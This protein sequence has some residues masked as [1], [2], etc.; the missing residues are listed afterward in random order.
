MSTGCQGTRP[1]EE[2]PQ[3]ND[4]NL[5]V[6]EWRGLDAVLFDLRT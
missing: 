4:E 2:I 5:T 3:L 1:V 6:P